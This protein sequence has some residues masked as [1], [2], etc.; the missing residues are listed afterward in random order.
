MKEASAAIQDLMRDTA[1]LFDQASKLNSRLLQI[2]TF[3]SSEETR[4]MLRD[5]DSC[6]RQYKS[7]LERAR[8]LFKDLEIKNTNTGDATATDSNIEELREER[9]KL[10]AEAV[11]K[12]EQ[13]RMLLDCVRQIQL[14]STQLL[15][16]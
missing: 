2:D 4:S 1:R 14:T 5:L 11:D 6:K 8:G 12:A 15:Q 3:F 9:D 13:I 7:S 16:I 10:Y